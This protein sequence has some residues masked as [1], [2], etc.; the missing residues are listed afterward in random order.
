MPFSALLVISEILSLSKRT[1]VLHHH[2]L[3]KK[4]VSAHLFSN[5]E[6]VLSKIDLDTNHDP[7]NIG[8][9]NKNKT[10]IG[11]VYE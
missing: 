6:S 7:G 5:L 8:V 2:Q 4:H 11:E 3:H 9:T 10:Q 1:P